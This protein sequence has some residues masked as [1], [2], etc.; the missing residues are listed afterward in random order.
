M[1]EC[2]YPVL[3][4]AFLFRAYRDFVGRICNALIWS[5]VRDEGDISK[6]DLQKQ[7]KTDGVEYLYISKQARE[8]LGRQTKLHKKRS[9][10]RFEIWDDDVQY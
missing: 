4:K 3:K 2:K 10:S 8:L 5:E 7:R 1:P 9:F 6:S